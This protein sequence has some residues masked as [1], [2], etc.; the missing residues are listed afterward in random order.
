MALFFLSIPL[1]AVMI[2]LAVVPLMVMSR[3]ENREITANRHASRGARR[4]RV[5]AHAAE[6]TLTTAA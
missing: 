5:D 2:A 6:P 4:E 1:M 3:A